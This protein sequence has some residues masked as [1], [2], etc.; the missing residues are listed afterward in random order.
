MSERYWYQNGWT[1]FW[2]VVVVG[3]VSLHFYNT[4][5]D[6]ATP[7][8][9]PKV[10]GRLH[11]P[12]FGTPTLEITAWHQYP[13]ALRNVQL[14]VSVNDDPARSQERWIQRV[15]SFESWSP[16][17]DQ[18]VTL[19]FPLKQYDPQLEIAVTILLAGKSVKMSLQE[20]VW[21]G[22]GWKSNP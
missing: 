18:A 12:L 4:A 7:S 19:T 11:Q 22:S 16:N 10:T 6:R 20:A 17:R 5:V 2:I 14:F 1:V 3:A 8:V 15:H 13:A 21:Q 9:T